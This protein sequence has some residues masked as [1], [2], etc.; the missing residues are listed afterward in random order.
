MFLCLVGCLVRVCLYKEE[1]N[2]VPRL[3]RLRDKGS[4]ISRRINKLFPVGSNF[5]ITYVYIKF[6]PVKSSSHCPLNLFRSLDA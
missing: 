2:R 6:V 5:Q 1:E 3:K 4:R